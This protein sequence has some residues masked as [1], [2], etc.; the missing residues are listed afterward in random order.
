MIAHYPV[1]RVTRNR[2]GTAS[3][4]ARLEARLSALDAERAALREQ[5]AAARRQFDRR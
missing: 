5:I 3:E 4:L 1:D 2:E